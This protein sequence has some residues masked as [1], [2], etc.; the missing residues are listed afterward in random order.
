MEKEQYIQLL[1]KG[2]YNMAVRS[3]PLENYHAEGCP[4]G[5]KEM[6]VI[7][8]YAYNVLCYLIK[9]MVDGD[10]DRFVTLC[11]SESIFLSYF[12]PPD[13]NSEEVKQLDSSYELI[14]DLGTSE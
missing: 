13:Y 3:G 11:A 7:N 10:T 6:E 1:A 2:M 9:M 5:D 14:K 4:I 12:D 8:R